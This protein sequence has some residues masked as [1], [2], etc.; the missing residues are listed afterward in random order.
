LLV[1]RGYGL[2][3]ITKIMCIS[4]AVEEMHKRH[5][6][7]GNLNP[8]SILVNVCGDGPY[9]TLVD[10]PRLLSEGSQG[11]GTTGEVLAKVLICQMSHGS[12]V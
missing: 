6:I 8:E 3:T 2:V 5:L 9:V 12:G 4:Q 1:P 7:H 11:E 10:L